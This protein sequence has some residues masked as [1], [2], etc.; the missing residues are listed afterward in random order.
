MEGINALASSNDYINTDPVFVGDINGDGRDDMIVHWATSSKKRQLLVY[1]A[2]ANGTL[3]AGVNLS[4][5]NT[6]DPAVYSGAFFIADVDGDGNDDFIVKWRNG[7]NIAFLTYRGTSSG[8]FS[9][10]VRTN[11][12][13]AIPYYI[14]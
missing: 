10:A 12:S 2:N 8:T 13:N 5:S 9:A 11:L 6:H 14:E 7:D 4:T 3:N 1:T